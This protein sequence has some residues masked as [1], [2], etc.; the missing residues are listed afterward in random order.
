MAIT[1]SNLRDYMLLANVD[2]IPDT[3]FDSAVTD[4]ESMLSEFTSDDFA[5]KNYAAYLLAKRIDFISI[6]KEGD[7]SF[8]KPKPEN[9]LELYEN[10][11]KEV[12]MY[13][14]KDARTSA[15]VYQE[16]V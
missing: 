8:N 10:R 16:N 3:A 2:S 5:T 6:A 11:I 12:N 1:G 4:A 9:Y 13:D 14:G 15:V 7:V